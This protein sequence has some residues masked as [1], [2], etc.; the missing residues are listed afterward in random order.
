MR[1]ILFSGGQAIVARVPR[2]TVAGGHVLVRVRYSLVSTGT[3]TASLRPLT[4]G[5]A[6]TTTA[7]RVSDLSSRASVYLSKAVR[8]PRK[9]AVK[10][11]EIVAAA[12]RQRV[13]EIKAMPVSPPIE[14]GAITWKATGPGKVSHKSGTT[15]IETDDSEASYQACSSAIEIPQHHA[16]VVHL[17]GKVDKGAIAVGLLNHDQSAWLG[18]YRL[19]EGDLDETLHFDP[20]GSSQVTLMITNA[21]SRLANRVT[22]ATSTATLVP[23][24]GSGLPVSE[25]GHQGWNVGYSVAG[26]V[27]AVGEGVTDFAIG[28][29]VSCCGAGVANH[30]DYVVAPRNL[31]CRIPKECP[32]ELAATATVGSIALQGVRRAQPQ[33]GEVVGVIGLGLIGMI[34]V[35]LLRASGARVIGVDLDPQRAERAIGIGALATT[36]DATE[37]LKLI[38]NLT[39]G[40]GADQVIV[41]AASKSNALINMAMDAAR[42][43]GKVV[44]VGD[45]GLKPERGAFY[46]KEIDLLM[47][48]SYGPGRYDADYELRGRDYPQ[49][50]VR[51]TLNRNMQ[52]YL[53][54]IGSKSIDIRAL[55][56]RVATID[57]AGALYREL[58]DSTDSPPLAVIF[59]YPEDTRP[60]PDPADSPVIQLRGHRK[61]QDGRINYAL[62]GAGGFGTAMLVPQMDKRKDRYFLKAVVS[63]DAVRGGNFARSKSVELLASD[64]ETILER[65]DIDLVVLATRHN[66]HARQVIRA[67][68]AGKHVFVEKPLALT[69]DELD[70]V[71]KAHEA[72]GGKNALMV[73]FNRRFSPAVQALAK[74]L[75]NRPAPL[76]MSYRMNAGYLP[77]SH[78]T[79]G[80][81]GGG[82]NI[83]EA[84][85]IY[86][87]L[88]FL[89]GAP[90]VAVQAAAIDPHGTAY[91]RNDNFVATMTYGDGSIGSLTYSAAGPKEGMPKERLEVLCDGEGYLL[92]DYKTLTRSSDGA[93]LWQGTQ[94]KGHYEE[95]SRLGDAIASGVETPIPFE[96]LSETTAISLLVEDQIFGRLEG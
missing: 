60:L 69:W 38:R 18:T 35:Q 10:L 39:G 66:E 11:K 62:V 95:L 17:R 74:V 49:A 76:V 56:D 22:I 29:Q 78:W 21:G 55:I 81:E 63:R 25:M 2:P 5:T 58:V 40:V 14:L 82:R 27:I 43:R 54:A 70:A 92:D 34:T 93:V 3:E 67:L 15:I 71:R 26:E 13:P 61:P 47:S 32:M 33:L 87:T 53:D 72:N 23:P 48:T 65:D 64:L 75:R 84:C 80:P 94:D 8:D 91:F 68:E 45:I 73:G 89:A 31:V 4:S 1:Q 20:A 90:A 30:A 50:Y 85:H 41:T 88:R 51:W 77:A 6:G 16:L 57:Q 12:L 42:R 28:D 86:D 59:A 24:D 7:E 83:G 52:A 9:A 46:Q 36:T 19:E 79:Q 37:F 96:E 44:I